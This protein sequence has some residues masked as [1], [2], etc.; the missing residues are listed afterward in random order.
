[1]KVQ[2]LISNIVF[3]ILYFAISPPFL[4]NQLMFLISWMHI[5]KLKRL[6]GDIYYS[7]L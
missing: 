3:K 6:Y 2:R 5:S 1:V 4:L 7:L